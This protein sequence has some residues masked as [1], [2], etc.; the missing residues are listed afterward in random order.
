MAAEDLEAVWATPD[1]GV[2]DA[3]AERPEPAHASPVAVRHSVYDE[4]PSGSLLC[5]DDGTVREIDATAAGFFGTSSSRAVGR[6]FTDL[7]GAKHDAAIR[8]FLARL[9]ASPAPVSTTLGALGARSEAA[10]LQ[11]LGIADRPRRDGRLCRLFLIEVPGHAAELNATKSRIFAAASHDLRQPLNA[12][13]L[14]L[15]II[16]TSRSHGRALDVAGQMQSTLDVLI[17]LFDSLLELTRYECG[18]TQPSRE[19]IRISDLFSRLEGELSETAA[20]KNLALRFVPSRAWAWSDPGLLQRILRNLISSAINHTD[21][22][23]ITVGAQRRGNALRISVFD[24]GGGFCDSELRR[25]FSEFYH[26]VRARGQRAEYYGLGLAT[27]KRAAA[28]LDH[29]I[30]VAS[31]LGHGS[32]LS[33]KVPLVAE[34]APATGGTS[35]GQPPTPAG[36]SR[37]VVV[38]EDDPLV[39]SAMRACLELCGCSVLPAS[40]AAEALDRV[41]SL[42]AP[43]LLV[44]SDYHLPG[45]LDGLQAI[46]AV[47]R[48][49]DC[50]IAACIIT[51]DLNGDLRARSVGRGVQAIMKPIKPERLLAMIE[52]LVQGQPDP[53]PSHDSPGKPPHPAAVTGR[54]VGGVQRSNSQNRITKRPNGNG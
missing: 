22:G 14:Y 37:T 36:N 42:G 6:S 8:H 30:D 1:D 9:Q 49:F 29:P 27:A 24:T 7:V 34:N 28:L 43:P 13:S 10:G 17:E 21:A 19:P 38:I 20:Q 25:L 48:R 11:V 3:R 33:L 23:R 44:I 12:L 2:P 16:Q 32:R 54:S 35:K 15:G 4:T 46:D 41:G 18:N 5:D 53:S 40:S 39:L 31:K 51:G 50:E 52:G 45:G 47:R 26:L